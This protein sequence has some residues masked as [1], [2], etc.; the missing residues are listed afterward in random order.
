MS[1]VEKKKAGRLKMDEVEIHN[2]E[3]FNKVR[4]ENGMP[5]LVSGKTTCLRCDKTFISKSIKSNRICY[6]CKTL[7]TSI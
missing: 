1:E 5:L 6:N 7:Q 4:K 2:I 3:V